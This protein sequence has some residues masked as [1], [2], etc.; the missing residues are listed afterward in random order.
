MKKQI[1]DLL[2]KIEDKMP[3][4]I[5]PYSRYIVIGVIALIVILT[6]FIVNANS[7][8]DYEKIGYYHAQN[9]KGK[10]KNP[11]SMI[12]Y[13]DIVY[14]S[15][16]TKDEE[17]TSYTFINYGGENSYGAIVKN[18]AIYINGSYFANTDA[19]R[20]D[21][22]NLDDYVIYT[23]AKLVLATYNL[24]GINCDEFKGAYV[25]DGKKVA[26]KLNVSYSEL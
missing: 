6:I 19:E 24:V 12:I 20:D 2:K 5:K 7:L 21:F 13:N 14:I 16:Y 25:I 3:E 18:T 9:L 23:R 4:K 10:L 22:D 17:H 26:R 8:K 15:H 1:I 11:D